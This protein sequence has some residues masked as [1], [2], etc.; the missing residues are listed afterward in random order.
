M[1][2]ID[3]SVLAIE[4]IKIDLSKQNQNLMMENF[5]GTKFTVI[6]LFNSSM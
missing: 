2:G 1:D 5:D 3:M 4:E 6:Y